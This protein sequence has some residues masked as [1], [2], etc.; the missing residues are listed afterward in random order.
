MPF[1]EGYPR[2]SKGHIVFPSDRAL[3]KDIFLERVYH[4]AHNNLYM[5]EELVKY[6]AP[7][8]VVCDPMAGAGSIMYATPRLKELWLIELGPY[9]HEMITKNGFGFPSNERITLYSG[10]AADK[11]QDMASRDVR[12]DAIIFSPPY[13]KQ[14][15]FGKGHAIYDQEETSA[16]Q[17]IENYTYDDP[18]NLANKQEFRFNLSMQKIYEACFAVS[19]PGSYICIIIKDRLVKGKRIS[20]GIHHTRLMH[21]AGYRLHEWHQREAVGAVFGH[22]N[23][24]KGIKQIV[25]EH[26]IICRRPE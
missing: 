20:Y 4:P 5:L 3:R 22:F 14:L 15:Q 12:T 18:D 25:D 7:D 13:S 6:L 9:F 24:K 16:G 23:I 17:G 26:I 10:D 19:K 2:N 8:G 11:L 21:K 1:A